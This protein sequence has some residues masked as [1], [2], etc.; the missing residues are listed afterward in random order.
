MYINGRMPT[1]LRM[2]Q[3]EYT[4]QL[5]VLASV[6]FVFTG[7]GVMIGEGIQHLPRTVANWTWI[8]LGAVLSALTLRQ[9]LIWFCSPTSDLQ[10]LVHSDVLGDHAL[11]LLA[12][13]LAGLLGLD[14]AMRLIPHLAMLA[15]CTLLGLWLPLLGATINWSSRRAPTPNAANPVNSSRAVW[16][17]LF[18][19]L[20]SC[21]ALDGRASPRLRQELGR[22]EKDCFFAPKALR[23]GP[24]TLTA[25]SS[26]LMGKSLAQSRPIDSRT[27]LARDPDMNVIKWRGENSLFHAWTEAGGKV[28]ILG[29]YYPYDSWFGSGATSVVQYPAH[30]DY[31]PDRLHAS[32]LKRV[33]TTVLDCFSSEQRRPGWPDAMAAPMEAIRSDMTHRVEMLQISN[34]EGL[35]WVHWPIPHPPSLSGDSKRGYGGNLDLVA[36]ELQRFREQQMR[37]G[38]WDRDVVILMADHGLRSHKAIP[39]FLT[40]DQGKDLLDG[41]MHVPFICRLP[42]AREGREFPA[43]LSL[44]ELRQLLCEIQTERIRTYDDLTAWASSHVVNHGI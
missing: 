28:R 15:L 30:F 21:I 29:W 10:L 22:W 2:L 42:G 35:T 36:T 20:D 43:E 26:L 14:R 11:P 8:I 13:L 32:F 31:W 9:V 4:L 33:F 1:D 5:A 37:T 27:I 40:P 6:L 7:V 34:H 18:D 25:I 12:A 16:V 3:G 23:S 17:L 41:G 38:C 24:D 39:D 19:E 44:V